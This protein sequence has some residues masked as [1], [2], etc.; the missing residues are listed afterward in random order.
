MKKLTTAL[1]ALICIFTLAACGKTAEKKEFTPGKI[2]GN[3]YTSEFAG[4]KL[5]AGSSWTF[6]TETEVSEF[7]AK[8]DDGYRMTDDGTVYDAILSNDASGVGARII[9]MY[10]SITK[11]SGGKQYSAEEYADALTEELESYVG[12]EFRVDSRENI[13]FCGAESIC[14]TLKDDALDIDREEAY[15]VREIGDYMLV[16]NLAFLTSSDTTLDGMLSMF[17][18]LDA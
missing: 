5:E 7:A 14:I 15:I 18:P 12:A 3:V 9:I 6:A 13:N 8:V 2:E 1:L 16:V 4:I 17:S 11:L 10:Q